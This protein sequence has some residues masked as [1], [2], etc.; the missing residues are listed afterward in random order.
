[1]LLAGH[2]CDTMLLI[3]LYDMSKCPQLKKP[4]YTIKNG[5]SKLCIILKWNASP[6]GRLSCPVCWNDISDTLRRLVRVN[7]L[8]YSPSSP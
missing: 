3:L 8:D 1:M 6:C 7:W 4:V 2:L 5:K